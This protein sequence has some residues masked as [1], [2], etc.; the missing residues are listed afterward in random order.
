MLHDSIEKVNRI[1][2]KRPTFDVEVKAMSVPT[3]ECLA[4][5]KKWKQPKKEE[6]EL[7]DDDEEEVRNIS[8]FA[9]GYINNNLP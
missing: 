2:S 5:S 6:K 3:R 7:E 4:Q 9:V 8:Q 1:E